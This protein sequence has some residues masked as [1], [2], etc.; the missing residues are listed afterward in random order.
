[1]DRFRHN[2][3]E[4]IDDNSLGLNQITAHAHANH[5]VY[6]DTNAWFSASSG[7]IYFGDASSSSFYNDFAKED[8]VVYHE[9]G[10]AVIYD[11]Q[12][13]IQS[14]SSEEGAISEG[15]PGYWSGSFTGRSII[16]N[17]IGSTRNM[18]NPKI[19]SYSQ[20]ESEEP[21]EAHDGGEF[22]SAILWDLRNKMSTTDLDFLVYDALYRVTGDPDFLGFRDALMAADNAAYGGSHNTI[23]QNT[24]A[25]WGIGIAIP[26]GLMVTISGPPYLNNGQS[27]YFSTSV[28]NADGSV[29]YQW[30]YRQETYS[31]WTA[32]GSN[33]ST[34]THTFIGAPG[35]Q[36]AHSAVKVEISSA[37]ETASEVFSVDVYG[38]KGSGLQSES[39]G[40]N[41]ITPCD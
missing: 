17:Y 25:D 15:T 24:F 30:Y 32:G 9:Y 7:N 11:I 14:N 21:V 10:H 4:G 29:S 26:T 22:F 28:S 23:I 18:A 3:I 1:M 41:F 5:P 39:V 36:T 2:F 27:G 34:Y 40:S 12:N 16:G 38:C 19:G 31:S 20:Y 8:K 6:G 13:G 37:G 35:G 33:S